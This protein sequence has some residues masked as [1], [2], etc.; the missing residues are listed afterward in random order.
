MSE[1]YSN[2]QSVDTELISTINELGSG[3]LGGKE[4]IYIGSGE[5]PEGYVLQIDPEGTADTIPT[6][7]S[8]LENDSGFITSSDL[9]TKT[10]QLVND[11]GFITVGDL[12]D[13]E[14]PSVTEAD[15]GKVL[16]VVGGVWAADTIQI[17]QDTSGWDLITEVALDAETAK[18]ILCSCDEYDKIE[19]IIKRDSNNTS[20]MGNMLF[21]IVDSNGNSVIELYTNSSPGYRE[22]LIIMEVNSGYAHCISMTSNNLYASTASLSR[23]YYVGNGCKYCLRIPKPDTACDGL[24][25]MTVIGRRR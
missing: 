15:N 11:S 16:R 1:T 17:E 3:D 13:P 2:M 18:Y 25:T 24:S 8:Q 5:M 4:E 19:I 22:G 6:K 9:P 7:T 14:L 20:L 10:S 12:P 23:G 21:E